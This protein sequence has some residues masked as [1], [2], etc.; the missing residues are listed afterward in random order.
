MYILFSFDAVEILYNSN[1]LYLRAADNDPPGERV[2]FDVAKF[3]GDSALYDKMAR[4]RKGKWH[5]SPLLK[6]ARIVNRVPE[7]LAAIKRTASSSSPSCKLR[8]WRV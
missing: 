4:D 1:L 6:F 3:Y 8:K 2:L 7:K 5:P